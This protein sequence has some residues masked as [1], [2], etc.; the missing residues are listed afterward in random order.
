M[1]GDGYKRWREQLTPARN[2][3]VATPHERTCR[4]R[5]WPSFQRTL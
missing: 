1:I 4:I 5:L 3:V 2:D